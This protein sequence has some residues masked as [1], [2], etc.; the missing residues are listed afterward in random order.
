[1]RPGQPLLLDTHVLIWIANDPNRIPQ[2][3]RNAINT[4]DA[5]YVSH[6]SSWEIQ[7]KSEKLGSRFLFSLDRL[8]ETMMS[9]NCTEMPIE[10]SDIQ[11]L[12]KLRFF[13]SDPFDRML[14][15]QAAGRDV[16]LASLDQEIV[17]TFEKERAFLLF[18]DRARG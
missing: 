3:L 10:Y 8:E 16:Y 9:L 11:R 5:R 18:S 12:N 13:H 6:V 2:S 17:N 7:I 14:M 15:S 1:L 4:A